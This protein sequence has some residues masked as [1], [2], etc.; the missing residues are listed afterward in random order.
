MAQKI[1][2]NLFQ[3]S[4]AGGNAATPKG[5]AL[6]GFW[7]EYYAG[8]LRRSQNFDVPEFFAVGYR[9]KSTPA[10]FSQGRRK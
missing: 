8:E 10:R 6:D 2:N 3:D 9:L 4:E 7:M 5:L 1:T